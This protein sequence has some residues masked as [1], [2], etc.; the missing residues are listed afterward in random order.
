MS[1]IGSIPGLSSLFNMQSTSNTTRSAGGKDSD[2]DNDGSRVRGGVGRSN[3]MSA[4]QQALGQTM[5]SNSGTSSVASSA[6]SSSSS[7]QDPQTAVA[8]KAFMQN[9][10]AALH[11]SSGQSNATAATGS[12]TDANT[13]NAGNSSTAEVGRHHHGGSNLTTNIQNLL[14]QLSSSSQSTS[15]GSPSAPTSIPSNGTDALRNLSSNFQN[16]ISALDTSQGQ[17]VPATTP[18]LQSF[19]QNLLQDLSGGQNIS[20]AVVSTKA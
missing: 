17:G 3:F 9:L 7:T 6:T 12:A 18:N 15:T 2:G 13:S 1:N 5:S 14:Q 11:Q 19:L 20:G 4:I 16:L 8:M 10:F